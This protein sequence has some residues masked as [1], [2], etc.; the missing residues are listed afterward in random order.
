VPI[1]IVVP[2]LIFTNP[3]LAQ[4]TAARQ[5]AYGV[6]VLCLLLAGI[7]GWW[8]SRALTRPLVTVT[9]RMRAI[10]AGNPEISPVEMEGTEWRQ[11]SDT[12]DHMN[13]ALQQRYDELQESASCKRVKSAIGRSSR[14]PVRVSGWSTRR[15]GRSMR[16]SAWRPCSAF[17]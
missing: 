8:L 11:L 9:R 17:R 2:I 1:A 14:P 5:Q 7:A 12:L 10:A 16:T 6:V 4:N 13:Q 15:G 3:A